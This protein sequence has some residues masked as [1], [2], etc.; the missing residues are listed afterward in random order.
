MTDMRNRVKVQALSGNLHRCEH[1]HNAAHVA[2][3]PA[4]HAV[5]DRKGL[6]TEQHYKLCG[7]VCSTYPTLQPCNKS[8]LPHM[9]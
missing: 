9:H 7:R 4:H 3:A 1:S 5:K 2:K 8:S 6:T